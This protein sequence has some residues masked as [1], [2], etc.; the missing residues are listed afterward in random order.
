LVGH[1]YDAVVV[2]AGSS[3][4]VVAARLA[5]DPDRS[6]LLVEAGPDFPDEAE[7]PPAFVTGGNI[8]G[9]GFAGAGAPTPDLD[10]GY[11][12]EPVANGR[13]V[14]LRRGRL[15]GGTSMINGSVAV[16]GAPR[17]FDR[18]RELIGACPGTPARPEAA[19]KARPAVSS[20]APL[21]DPV[22]APPAS[23]PG[24]VSERI[25]NAP[26]FPDRPLGAPGWGWDDVRL[27]FERVESVVPIKR[28]AADRWL[29]IQHSFVD[30]FEE[31][32][33]RRVEDMNTPDAWDG[34]V[35]AWPQNRRNEIRQG[36]LVTYVRDARSRPNLEIRDRTLVDRVLLDGS[37][38]RGV[39]VVGPDDHTGTIE[40][41]LVVLSGGAYGS[42]AVLLRS[43]IGPADDVRATGIEPLADLPVGRSLRDHPQCFFHLRTPPELAAMGGPGF[44][45]VARGDGWWSFPLALDEAAGLCA[46][47]FALASEDAS[48]TVT[49]DSAD[50]TAA[51]RIDHRYR[52]VIA[53]GEFAGAYETFRA[54]AA[55]PAL[56]GAGATNADEGLELDAILA[57]RLGTAFHPCGTCAMGAVVDEELRVYGVDGLR[58]A[59]AS[60]FPAH[61]TNNPKLTCFMVGERDAELIRKEAGG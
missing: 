56:A 32:G 33:F 6:V 35:G 54:L 34:V 4:A 45:V 46:V 40:A 41:D 29:P 22:A 25:P 8:L 26:G 36:T 37:R 30:G 7:S 21:L 52:D 19:Q 39:Q 12:S 14:H 55:A 38:V 49:L 28:Y 58:V 15:V 47:A 59:D 20:E 5:E 2:G 51:P 48:G 11:W 9:E 16:R 27:Y 17:D 23:L 10:W 50:P 43:G 53:R 44:A 61:V 3:G 24:G 57:E 1:R 31:L 18:W 60:I 13:R 42:P